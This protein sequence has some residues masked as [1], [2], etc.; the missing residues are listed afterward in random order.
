M[1]GVAGATLAPTGHRL[2]RRGTGLGGEGAAEPDLPSGHPS[3]PFFL[4]L[5]ALSRFKL[6]GWEAAPRE[7]GFAR[8]P[9]PPGCERDAEPGCQL[10]LNLV[11]F[12]VVQV[13]GG[14]KQ[15]GH[16]QQPRCSKEAPEL[17]DP[18]PAHGEQVSAA[19]GWGA[20]APAGLAWELSAWDHT[21]VWICVCVCERERERD[22]ERKDAC[23]YTRV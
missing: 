10:L 1:G 11:F 18:A 12:T 17:G 19:R 9:W 15:G 6:R 22:R 23:A 8:M 4:F 14:R 20:A 5:P 2:G 3:S 13:L 7:P 16:P 21:I